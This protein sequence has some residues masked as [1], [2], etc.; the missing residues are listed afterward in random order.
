[1]LI[2][3]KPRYRK[4]MK[5]VRHLKGVES[6]GCELAFGEFG[7]RATESGWITNRQIEASRIALTR[8]AKRGGKVWIKIFPDKPLTK[9]PAETRMGSGKGAPELWVAEVRA[10]RVLFEITGVTEEIARRAF[11][12]ASAKLPLK[13]KFVARSQNII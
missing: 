4:Q 1:M 11:E 7:L 3:K 12:L 8:F 10:G 2:P 6:R 9:K 5:S 13:S